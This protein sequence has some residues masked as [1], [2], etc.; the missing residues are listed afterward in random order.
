MLSYHFVEH[1]G[2]KNKEAHVNKKNKTA[3]DPE[4]IKKPA[5]KLFLLKLKV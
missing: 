3:D 1:V 5:E 4:K 2:F